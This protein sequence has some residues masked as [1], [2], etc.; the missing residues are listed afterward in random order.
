MREIGRS[1]RTLHTLEWLDQF[2]S[3]VLLVYVAPIG[4]QHIDLP[5]DCL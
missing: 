5:D 2:F 3:D 4:W 1:V